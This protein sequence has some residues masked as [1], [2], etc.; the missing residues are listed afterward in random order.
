[1]LVQTHFPRKLSRSRYD[2]YLAS[3]WFRG[4]V[5]LYKMNLLCIDDEVY[6]VVNIRLNI[7]E[8]KHKK[9]QRKLLRKAE[10]RFEIK[11]GKASPTPEKKGYTNCISTGSRD[12]STAP[13]TS[14]YTL[15]STHQYLTLEKYAFTIMTS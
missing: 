6:S 14:T 13:L 15:I 4:S 11:F 2:Q 7:E 10:E 1:M 5:M 12:S 3:G 8:F 9:R